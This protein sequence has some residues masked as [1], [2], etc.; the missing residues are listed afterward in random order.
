MMADLPSPGE[1][2]PPLAPPNPDAL[3]SEAASPGEP[4]RDIPVTYENAERVFNEA[5]VALYELRAA[6]GKTLGL[7][8][9]I[10]QHWS[11]EVRHVCLPQLAVY[12]SDLS[13]SEERAARAVFLPGRTGS[14]PYHYR[15]D[16]LSPKDLLQAV[17]Q[18]PPAYLKGATNTTEALV[19]LV[20]YV[21]DVAGR[22]PQR[23]DAEQAPERE[24]AAQLCDRE[25]D[26]LTT[27]VRRLTRPSTWDNPEWGKI[28]HLLDVNVRNQFDMTLDREVN[29]AGRRLRE[30]LAVGPPPPKG[31]TAT[32]SGSP[33]S[34]VPAAGH[35]P[36]PPSP[37]ETPEAVK[38][39]WDK[40][41]RVL[42]FGV[43]EKVYK[44]NAKNQVRV[45]DAFQKAGWPDCID[46]SL[47]YESPNTTV[48][49]MNY[50]LGENRPITF[51]MNGKGD[52][53]CW[54]VADTPSESD[55]S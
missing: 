6:I 43:W 17:G 20:A 4:E 35:Q 31:D 18:T 11:V 46:N 54:R 53:I 55:L 32:G 36:P 42:R 29:Q 50:S 40:E 9:F 45:L 15:W 39:V 48:R 47:K 49:D 33:G 52:G 10:R 13:T 34:D 28:P 38:P 23:T 3:S 16:S 7:V 12:M 8:D 22:P 44:T 27:V 51:A 30:L 1:G 24:V 21:L 5:K 25:G 19:R 41:K 14:D 26:R 37:P 2:I